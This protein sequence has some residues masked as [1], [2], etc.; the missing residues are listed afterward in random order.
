MTLRSEEQTMRPLQT[1]YLIFLR[2][3]AEELWAPYKDSVFSL[4]NGDYINQ[5]EYNEL[6]RVLNLTIIEQLVQ[7]GK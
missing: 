5:E 2:H 3:A 4:P 7:E 6:L 1:N